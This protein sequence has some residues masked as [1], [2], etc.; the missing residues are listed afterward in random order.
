MKK[1]LVAAIAVL[2][3]S[4]GLAQA[5]TAAAPSDSSIWFSAEY[6]LWWFKKSP[7]PVPL[8]TTG[9][10][11][12][13]VPPGSPP[14]GAIGGPTT[15]VLIGEH[16]IDSETHS[17][18]RFMAGYWC[19]GA[20]TAGFDGGYFFTGTRSVSQFVASNGS[21]FL[22]VPFRNA[23]TG[24]E[25]IGPIDGLPT[26]GR[27]LVSGAD[28]LTLASSL[29]GAELNA[30]CNVTSCPGYRLDVL[31]GFR[32]LRLRED[33]SFATLSTNAPQVAA[34]PLL[35]PAAF[36]TRD[37]FDAHNNFY[38]GQV[39]FRTEYNCGHIFFNGAG[40]IA[41]GDMHETLA[42]S[43]SSTLATGRTTTAFAGGVFAQPTN[44]GRFTRDHFAAVPEATANV[45]Y[46]FCP[47]ARVFVGY[48]FLYASDVVRP[49]DQIDHTINP[50]RTAVAVSE[51]ITPVG[52]LRPGSDLRGSDFW[53]QGVNAGLEFHF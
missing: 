46:E 2:L 16:S 19:D 39:G 9:N 48:T 5:Q 32:W 44:I 26:A 31:A 34:D 35:I 51:G 3:A 29:Q 6:L 4:A 18:G 13:T 37:E 1:G 41:L 30:D 11:A 33:L 12:A 50:T 36:R 38:G 40:K 20:A 14:V 45:G 28:A 10:T 17:G 49:G 7:E 15:Q 52:P 27:G 23:I 24:A 47:H 43:G 25:Q 42:I 8:V 21:T 53:A 22:A